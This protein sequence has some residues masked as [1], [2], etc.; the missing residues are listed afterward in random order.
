M[1]FK[2]LL[3]KP[4]QN[5]LL[6]GSLVL[7]SSLAVAEAPG[8]PDC[9]WGNLMFEGDSGKIAHFGASIFNGSSGNAWIGM[10]VGTNGCSTEGTIT[11]GGKSLFALNGFMD[12]VAVDVAKGEGEALNA[13]SVVL[14]IESQDRPAFNQLLQANFGRI[15]PSESINSDEVVASINAVMKEDTHF[16]R[17]A[18]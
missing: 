10:L 4:F 3:V 14:G 8:G 2:S 16:S 9:G 17:Y 1:S 7:A 12:E 15:F 18:S 13:L 11:Y 5:T 6:A